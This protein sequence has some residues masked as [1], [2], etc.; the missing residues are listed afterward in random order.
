MHFLEPLSSCSTSQTCPNV[1]RLYNDYFSLSLSTSS[2]EARSA[3]KPKPSHPLTHVSH[4][5]RFF[6][7]G[8]SLHCA[9]SHLTQTSFADNLANYCLT[10]SPLSPPY[11]H[12]TLVIWSQQRSK[13]FD[14]QSQSPKSLLTASSSIISHFSIYSSSFQTCFPL[15]LP[16]SPPPW[17]LLILQWLKTRP[18]P[19][20]PPA[21][22]LQLVV[23]P[24]WSLASL[25]LVKL[26]PDPCWAVTL[27]RA[28][29]SLDSF[30]SLAPR[31][32]WCQL[33]T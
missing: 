7:I 29:I 6:F 15:P 22:A 8:P 12:S 28:P 17:P 13:S 2:T 30:R 14:S 26:L 20:Q 4:P 11:R 31:A 16:L 19:L 9:A 1:P 33:S 18:P 21:R 3:P 32:Q 24:D 23:L 10:A 5:L 27:V 25:H